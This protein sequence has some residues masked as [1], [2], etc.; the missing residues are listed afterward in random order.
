M[1]QDFQWGNPYD[2]L[3]AENVQNGNVSYYN[4]EWDN[5]SPIGEDTATKREASAPAQDAAPRKDEKDSDR[6]DVVQE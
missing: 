4:F 5:T 2:D 1:N 3:G 6:Y